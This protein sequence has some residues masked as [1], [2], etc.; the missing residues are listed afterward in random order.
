[1]TWTIPQVMRSFREQA[2]KLQTD[3]SRHFSFVVHVNPVSLDKGDAL[4]VSVV[5]QKFIRKTNLVLY[6]ARSL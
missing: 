3:L 4:C 2:H 1:M 6:V 5:A